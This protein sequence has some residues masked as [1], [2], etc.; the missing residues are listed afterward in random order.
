M[1][2]AT[3]NDGRTG[4]GDNRLRDVGSAHQKRA[5]GDRHVP[6][7]C[8]ASAHGAGL[9]KKK[10]KSDLSLTKPPGPTTDLQKARGEGTV[11]GQHGNPVWEERPWESVRDK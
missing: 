8:P 6:A 10:K 5:M 7:S 1:L 4:D 11:S 2:A 3:I 9:A